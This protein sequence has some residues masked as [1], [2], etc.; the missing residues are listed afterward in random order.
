M[1]GIIDPTSLPIGPPLAIVWSDCLTVSSGEAFNSGFP[2]PAPVPH[3]ATM[4]HSDNTDSNTTHLLS[5]HIPYS[6]LVVKRE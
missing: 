5:W 1:A 3:P 4:T 2:P 6:L